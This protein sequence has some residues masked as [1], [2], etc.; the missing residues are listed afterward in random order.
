M[1]VFIN[2][3]LSESLDVIHYRSCLIQEMYEH[4]LSF[5]DAP[6][7]SSVRE[8]CYS[9]AVKCAHSWSAEELAD[10]YHNHR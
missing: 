9:H 7:L 8:D 3:K 6:S 10:W 4:E 1:E 5:A 2:G